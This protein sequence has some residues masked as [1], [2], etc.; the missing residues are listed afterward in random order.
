[1]DFL[2]GFE[3]LFETLRAQFINI[4]VDNFLGTLYVILN[5]I[6]MLFASLIDG[7]V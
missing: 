1:M 5:S 2:D 7:I 6:L 4:P 3:Q